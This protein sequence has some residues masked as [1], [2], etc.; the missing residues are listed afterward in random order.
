MSG[1]C[2]W[3]SLGEG[4]MGGLLVQEAAASTAP[5]ITAPASPLQRPV[6]A[7]TPP[8][9]SA[10]KMA[11]RMPNAARLCLGAG[12]QTEVLEKRSLLHLPH[13]KFS[14]FR[15]ETVSCCP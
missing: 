1:G 9:T 14:Q 5:R 6:P 13:G 12:R 10:I 2:A 15:G 8:R 3:G 4:G 11:K 7:L